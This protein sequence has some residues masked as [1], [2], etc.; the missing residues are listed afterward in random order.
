VQ[1]LDQAWRLF[2]TAV[3]FAT[4]GIGGLVIGTILFPLIHLFSEN[5]PTAV[6]R[7]QIVVGRCFALFIWLMKGL[8]VL[9]YRWENPERL[10]RDGLLV[11]ANHPSLIDV[12]FII[13]RM[14]HTL[15]VVKSTHWSSPCLMGVMRAT[16]YIP[17]SDPIRLVADC[18]AALSRG[19]SL[20]IFPEGTRT[21]IGGEMQMKR[22]AASIIAASRKA[23]TPVNIDVRPRTLAKHESWHHIPASRPHWT[24][25]VG[26]DVNPGRAIVEG[27]ALSRN[28]RRVNRL[29]R[30]VLDKAWIYE[31]EATEHGGYGVGIGDQAPDHLHA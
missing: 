11:V 24:L 22:G 6:R 31:N 26:E 25:R 10:N 7:C 15:C 27:D 21:A 14:P 8:G 13:S 28:N 18:A 9:T 30:T 17:N 1:R 12:V 29:L 23:F 5:R 4:F 19:H 3:S 20:V 2:G 16:G